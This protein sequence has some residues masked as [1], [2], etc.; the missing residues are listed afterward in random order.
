MGHTEWLIRRYPALNLWSSVELQGLICR[1]R[2]QTRALRLV[3]CAVCLEAVF[4][5]ALQILKT[6]QPGTWLQ[7]AVILAA[8]TGATVLLCDWMQARVV[9]CRLTAMMHR[10]IAATAAA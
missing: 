4:Y 6:A 1:A 5:S 8:I 9:R 7:E 10:D 3:V 2:R